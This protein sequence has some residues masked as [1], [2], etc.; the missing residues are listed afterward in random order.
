MGGKEYV[1]IMRLHGDVSEDRLKEVMQE[2]VGP[3][4]QRPPLRSSVK[5]SLRVKMVYYFEL[6]ELE[7]RNALFR[8][9]C[10]AGT[11]VRKICHD[12]GEA[13]GCGAHMRELRRTRVG[14]LT[15][16]E[17]V[18]LQDLA[19][20]YA[21]WQE[22]GDETYLRK[23]I[24]PLEAALAAVPKVFIRDTAVDAICHGASLAIPGVVKLEA[25]I[26][27]GDLVAVMTLKGEAVALGVAQM[28]SEEMMEAE[29]GIAV[30]TD[31]V[32]MKPGTYPSYWKRRS[33]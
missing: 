15:E 23:C 29:S 11:Y 26:K 10:E 16:Q 24:L 32:I 12:V 21:I 31:R 2:F 1:G 30:K 7:G 5:R 14:P 19:D 28:S 8:I 4:Y 25:G 22:T 27:K 33:S 3:Q 17:A 13:L 6:L 18:T 9:G 20:A